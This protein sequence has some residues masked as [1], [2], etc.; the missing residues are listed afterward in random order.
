[1][2][3]IS[4][5]TK[6]S[7]KP[8]KFKKKDYRPWDV[9]PDPLKIHGVD[10]IER[11]KVLETPSASNAELYETENNFLDLEKEWRQLYGAK[12]N[13]LIYIL[14]NIEQSDDNLEIVTKSITIEQL[15]KDLQLP[16]NTI[17]GSLYQLR[18]AGFFSKKENKPGRGGYTIYKIT[19]ELFLFFKNK[20]NS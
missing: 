9:I 5:L 7:E 16:L 12:K 13:I 1:M 19:K 3:L 2:P 15:A 10:K 6:N 14:K 11:D 17:K 18:K 4:N 20:I 8:K